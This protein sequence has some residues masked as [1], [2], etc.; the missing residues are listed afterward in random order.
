MHR[1]L[2][3]LAV[4]LLALLAACDS[5]KGSDQASGGAGAQTNCENQGK[6]HGN[7]PAECSTS[8]V[9]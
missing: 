9:K 6:R 1:T 3:L 2:P 8:Y 5:M 7:G 4:A